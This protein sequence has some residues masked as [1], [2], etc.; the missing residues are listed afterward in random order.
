VPDPLEL[1]GTTT[2]EILSER[3]CRSRPAQAIVPPCGGLGR[4]ACRAQDDDNLVAVPAAHLGS[5][6]VAWSL[7]AVRR[8]AQEA[9]LG[10]E[11]R[12]AYDDNAEFTPGP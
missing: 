10:E 4:G 12:D 1:A 7:A 9:R 8:Q 2:G 5:E 11:P 3:A 6:A